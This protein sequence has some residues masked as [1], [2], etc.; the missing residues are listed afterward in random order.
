MVPPIFTMFVLTRTSDV[1][2]R[3]TRQSHLFYIPLCK[4]NRRKMTIAYIGSKLWN[5]IAANIDTH[6]AIGTFKKTLKTFVLQTFKWTW[7]TMILSSTLAQSLCQCRPG[8]HSCPAYIKYAFLLYVYV[9]YWYITI[10]M[11]NNIA[12]TALHTAHCTYYMLV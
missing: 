7:T 2:S 4:T 9:H 12:P 6:C 11:L 5:I 3:D 1:H 10:C 8:N